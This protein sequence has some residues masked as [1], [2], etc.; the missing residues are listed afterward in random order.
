[1]LQNHQS[2]VHVHRVCVGG[3]G[4]HIIGGPAWVQGWALSGGG[5]VPEGCLMNVIMTALAPLESRHPRLGQSLWWLWVMRPQCLHAHAAPAGVLVCPAGRPGE[6]SLPSVASSPRAGGGTGSGG[7]TPLG[8]VPPPSPV[9]AS[10]AFCA[11]VCVCVCACLCHEPLSVSSLALPP[12]PVI[13]LQNIWHALST[14]PPPHSPFVQR[15]QSPKLIRSGRLLYI[16]QGRLACACLRTISDVDG[17]HAWGHQ[18]ST[19]WHHSLLGS[20]AHAVHTACLGP[21]FLTAL[22][23]S[24]HEKEV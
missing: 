18:S 17:S 24:I 15:H 8:Y 19:G 5:P 11:C 3:G 6:V 4:C 20:S 2:N 7:R 23:M 16:G 21:R 13:F 14:C 9:F 22:V 1:M 10:L 12:L